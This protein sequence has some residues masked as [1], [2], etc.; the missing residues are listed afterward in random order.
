MYHLCPHYASVIND[1]FP[2]PTALPL[3]KGLSGVGQRAWSA[4]VFGHMI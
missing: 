2:A 1:V 3:A 4:R